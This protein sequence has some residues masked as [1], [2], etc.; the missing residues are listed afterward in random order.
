MKKT[1]KVG[2]VVIGDGEHIPIQSMCNIPFSRFDELKEQSLALQ[3]AGCE[4]LR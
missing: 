2:N 4:I 3:N 1:V